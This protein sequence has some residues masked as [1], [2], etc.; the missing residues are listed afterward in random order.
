[1]RLKTVGLIILSSVLGYALNCS[2]IKDVKKWHGHYYTITVKRLTFLKAKQFAE[3]NGG[4]L[5][6][7]NSQAENDF[8]KS[9]I[10]SAK[11][12]WIG[13][14]DPQYTSNYCYDD[15][16]CAF[17]DSRFTDI[18]GNPLTYTNWAKNQPDNL[19]K[20]YDII[21]GKQMVSPLGEHWVAM[22][23]TN[24]KWADFGN[25]YDEYNNPVKHFALIEFDKQPE[26]YTPESNVT[27]TFSGAK[28]NTHIYDNTTG[29]VTPGNTYTCLQD[30][31]G[32]YYCPAGLAP[33]GQTWSYKD[34]YAVAHTG[35]VKD[36]TDK[37]GSSTYTIPIPLGNKCSSYGVYCNRYAFTWD[38][39]GKQIIEDLLKQGKVKVYY[40]GKYAGSLTSWSEV[41]KYHDQCDGFG[42]ATNSWSAGCFSGKCNR[43]HYL[44]F[45]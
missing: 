8:L 14:Y 31:N 18:K 4:Y 30:P 24:G 2:L 19:V 11:Y 25:H 13:V 32:N 23:S 39:S 35:D 36:Y 44:V 17:D 43:G 16:H 33:C 9:L 12:A 41:T 6:I 1:M 22:S 15:T 45:V 21:N 3:A 29:E 34:G 37:I 5:A 40:D 27:D 10:P 7:P 26:C 38:K 20:P 42:I 28:C